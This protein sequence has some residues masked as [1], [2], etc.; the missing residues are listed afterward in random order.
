M[1]YFSMEGGGGGGNGFVSLLSIILKFPFRHY[2]F[3]TI[4]C[5]FYHFFVNLSI[6]RGMRYNLFKNAEKA[7]AGRHI[8][9]KIWYNQG[10]MKRNWLLPPRA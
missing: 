2:P 4:L 7:Y 1:L 3:F 10:D 8:F 6:A 9:P 5:L